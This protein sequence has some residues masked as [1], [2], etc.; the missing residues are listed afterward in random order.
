[1]LLTFTNYNFN[2]LGLP[3]QKLNR[4]RRIMPELLRGFLDILARLQSITNGEIS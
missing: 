2:F 3:D 1:M 4:N